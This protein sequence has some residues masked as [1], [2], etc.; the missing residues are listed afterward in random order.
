MNTFLPVSD[1]VSCPIYLDKRRC[2]KQLV[3]T[4]QILKVLDG[5]TTA[6]CNHPAVRMWRGYRDCL[7]YYYN[8][9]YDYCVKVHHVKIVKLPLPILLPT[10][11]ATPAWMGYEPLHRAYRANLLRKGIIDADEKGNG[12]L[13]QK[14]TTLGISTKDYDINTPYI[15]PIDKNGKLIEQIEQHIGRGMI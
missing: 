3:E 9:F 8:I 13:L 1:F 4:Y 10:Y 14:L 6:W 7:Q 15:W 11:F 2:F 12:E 5:K